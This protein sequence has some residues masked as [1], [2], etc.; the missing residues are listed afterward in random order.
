MRKSI[1]MFFGQ[2]PAKNHTGQTCFTGR[3]TSF[4]NSSSKYETAAKG[5]KSTLCRQEK[6]NQIT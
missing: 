4:F 2:S 3:Q 5:G 1:S 6:T